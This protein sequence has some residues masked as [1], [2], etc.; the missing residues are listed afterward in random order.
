MTKI[1]KIVLHCSDSPFG[2]ATVIRRWHIERGWR[3]IG[4]HF[5]VT[6][7]N[8]GGGLKLP[9]FDGL[10]ETGRELDGDGYLTSAEQGAHAYGFNSDS[11]AICMIGIDTFTDNQFSALAILIQELKDQFG[12][13]EIIGHSDLDPNK[14]CPNFNIEWFIRDY[15]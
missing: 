12:E 11:I 5:V 2:S 8:L 1:K 6:N 9:M 4:Y 13:L 10:V 7:G 15:L 3:D 14:T